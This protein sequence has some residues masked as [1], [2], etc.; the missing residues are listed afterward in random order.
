[1]PDTAFP[2]TYQLKV[3]LVGISPMIWRRFLVSG[4]ST[5]SDFH[6]TLQL[7]MGWSDTHL[8]Q[9]IMGLSE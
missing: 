9:F 4:D 1:M 5:V 8:N 3:H 7:V 2:V 6:Y